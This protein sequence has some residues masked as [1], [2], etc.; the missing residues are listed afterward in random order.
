M[1]AFHITVTVN[2]CHTKVAL[3]HAYDSALARKLEYLCLPT[4]N[5]LWNYATKLFHL[6][7]HL[8]ITF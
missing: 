2:I 3:I 6:A 4:E 5:V 1:F 8:T 7:M